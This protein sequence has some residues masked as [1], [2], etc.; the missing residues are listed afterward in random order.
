[1]DQYLAIFLKL[2][3]VKLHF[4]ENQVKIVLPEPRNSGRILP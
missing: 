4:A 2:S 3:T 1:M